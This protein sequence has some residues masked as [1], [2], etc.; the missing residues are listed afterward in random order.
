MNSRRSLRLIDSA[1]G[2]SI[3]K[4]KLPYGGELS[5]QARF[6]RRSYIR[7]EIL[8][9]SGTL[10]LSSSKIWFKNKCGKMPNMVFDYLNYRCPH[11]FVDLFADVSTLRVDALPHL[12]ISNVKELYSISCCPLHILQSCNFDLTAFN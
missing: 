3:F 11:F 7:I 12:F 2:F 1:I 10:Q 5:I 4:N 9:F 6:W 8:S